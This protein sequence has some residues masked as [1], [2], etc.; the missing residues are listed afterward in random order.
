MTAAT[1]NFGRDLSCT[2][3]IRT[4]RFVSGPRL[5]AESLYRRLTTPRGMLRGGDDESDFGLDLLDLVGSATTKNDAAALEGKIRSEA[6]KDERI[7]SV[8]VEVLT[9]TEGAVTS[10]E[11][12][13]DATTSAGPFSL[14]LRVEDVTIELVGLSVEA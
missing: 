1:T 4:G 10:F 2:T 6:A 5:V 14:Q 9:V 12:A 3:S 11:I 8:D 13:I 7:E